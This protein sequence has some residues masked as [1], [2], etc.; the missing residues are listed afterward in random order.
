MDKME[1]DIIDLN[2]KALVIGQGLWYPMEYPN[3][4]FYDHYKNDLHGKMQDF[5]A[6][7]RKV[8]S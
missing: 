5:L 4:S 6:L 7:N 3:S 2:P 1:K 8:V